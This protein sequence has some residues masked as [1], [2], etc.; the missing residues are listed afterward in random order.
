MT[1]ADTDGTRPLIEASTLGDLL[2]HGAREWPARELLVFPDE[3]LTYAGLA[4]RALHRARALQA[5]G[6]Q[7]GDH[8]GILAPNLVEVIELLFACALS[9]AVAVLVNARYKSMELAYVVENADLKLLFTTRRTAGHVDFVELLHAALPGLR[10]AA[11]PWTLDLPGAPQLRRVILMEAGTAAGLVEWDRFLARAVEVDEQ[12]AWR[13]RGEVALRDPCIMMYTS[14]TTSGPKGCRLSHE[15]IVRS[16]REIGRRFRMTADDRQWNPLPMFH[17]SSIMPLLAGMWAG[18]S[19]FSQVVFEADEAIRIIETERPT[20]LYT[21][22]PTIMAGLVQHPRFRPEIV[23]QVRLVNNVAPPDQLRKNM[24]LVPNAVHI[25]AYGLTEASG[26][27]CYGSA[28]EDDDTR[29]TTCGSAL[30]GVQLRIVDPETGRPLPAGTPGEMTIKGFSVFEGYWKSPEKNREVFD[31]GGWFHT[32]D[33]CA[34]DAAG[35]VSYL[36][37]IK[38]M[39][40]VGGENVAAL[41]IESY[42]CTHA[43]VLIAQVVGMPDA[44]LTEVPAAFIQLKP[45]ATCSEEEII[46]F[47]KGRI[48]SYKVPRV[49]RFVDEWPMSSTKIQKH[50]L[51]ESLLPGF[52]GGPAAGA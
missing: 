42:L 51:R 27:S 47:C 29:A 36:G 17:L 44:R 50:R 45:G 12:D 3:R 7:P 22:F 2:L 15:M 6:V 33:R 11:D 52:A 41:E 8:V 10:E 34:M 48:A 25:S 37:R 4:G 46:A 32:G 1:S 14:G 18:S 24:K 35:R 30:S 16:A 31:A 21:A 39:L 13:R 26:I 28:D 40:K 23:G 5:L 49:V 43:A 9:G 38:D 20:F 19:F